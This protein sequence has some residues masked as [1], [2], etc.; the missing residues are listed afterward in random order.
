MIFLISWTV[1]GVKSIC[2]KGQLKT[3][4]RFSVIDELSLK[5]PVWVGLVMF[6]KYSLKIHANS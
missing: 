5:L 2:S 1:T 3:K 6:K 4:F